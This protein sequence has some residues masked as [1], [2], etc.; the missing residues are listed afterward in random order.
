M[1]LGLQ[2]VAQAKERLDLAT[3]VAERN[4]VVLFVGAEKGNR[5]M[6]GSR[7]IVVGSDSDW[8]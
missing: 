5:V 2:E 3:F 7:L 6:E 8:R 4:G 1:D